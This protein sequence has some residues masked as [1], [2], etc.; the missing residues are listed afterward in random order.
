[1][2][3]F[4]IH[5]PPGV[6]L[7]FLTKEARVFPALA[8]GMQGLFDLAGQV[9]LLAGRLLWHRAMPISMGVYALPTGRETLCH[10]LPRLDNH[11]RQGADD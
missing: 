1:M 11:S 2:R 9:Q 4:T 10:P 8:L 6:L 5:L 7:L 3:G